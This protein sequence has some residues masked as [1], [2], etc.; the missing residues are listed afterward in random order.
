MYF[1]SKTIIK[2]TFSYCHWYSYSSV[3]KFVIEDTDENGENWYVTINNQFT[4]SKMSDL[5]LILLDDFS[6]NVHISVQFRI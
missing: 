1:L 5:A 6:L 4:V 2:E 3:R